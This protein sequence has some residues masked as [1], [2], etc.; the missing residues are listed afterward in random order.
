MVD[1]IKEAMRAGRFRFESLEGQIFG[2]KDAKGTYYICEGHHRVVAALEMFWEDGDRSGSTSGVRTAAYVSASPE[3]QT[4]NPQL[5]VTFALQ[6]RPL[7]MRAASG[8]EYR[9]ECS[10]FQI[11]RLYVPGF[12]VGGGQIVKLVIPQECA[13]EEEGIVGEICRN[14][15]GKDRADG[16]VVT[17]EFPLT[18]SMLRELFHRQTA[19]E[20]L[21]ARCGMARSDAAFR[22]KQLQVDPD[23]PLAALAGNPRWLIGFSAAIYRQPRAVVFTTIGCDALGTQ[24]ALATAHEQLNGAAGVYVTSF[25]DL[26]INEPGYAAVLRVVS[27]ELERAA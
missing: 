16:V 21:V 13:A 11:G 3:S 7:T 17:P 24:R 12:E 23:A 4:S 22:L 2:W 9:L 1:Q 8:P 10:G 6:D 19:A 18:R 14:I 20:W 15:S 25:P 5:L 27:R 26:G